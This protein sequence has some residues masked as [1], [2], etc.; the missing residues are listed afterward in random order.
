[1]VLEK[2]RSLLTEGIVDNFTEEDVN[3]FNVSEEK[4]HTFVPQYL[5][6]NDV[7]ST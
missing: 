5:N 1:M 3:F 7:G 6:E 4:K 2:K